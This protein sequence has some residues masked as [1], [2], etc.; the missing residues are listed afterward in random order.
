MRFLVTAGSTRQ[1][2]D[3]VRDWG[4]VF[5]GNTGFGI[6]R[7]LLALGEVDLLTSNRGHLAE[8]AEGHWQGMAARGFVTHADLKTALTGMVVANRYDAV[9][10]T[11]AVSD[12]TPTGAYSIIRRER[13]G[14]GETEHWTVRGVQA[15]K[16]KSCYDRIAVVG[17]PTEK[18]VDL[19]RKSWDYKGMLVKFKL[20]VGLTTQ[21]LLEVGERSRL[22]SDADYLVANTLEMVNGSDAGAYLLG[23]GPAQWI[24]RDRLAE[25]LAELVREHY[26]I[27][28]VHKEP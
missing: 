26:G 22:A 28:Q 19:F 14:N 20:E 23:A 16:V 17:E 11:A 10:M 1:P 25:R 13:L 6:A 21:E 15:G 18:L 27:T 24:V 7:A 4:N 2:I 8:V 9:F 5:S 3:K 12:Y